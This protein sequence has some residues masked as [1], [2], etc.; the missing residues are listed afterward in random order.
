MPLSGFR[1][2]NERFVAEGLPPAPNPRNASPARCGRRIRA[3]PPNG[4]W[5]CGP[6]ASASAKGS[7]S[8]RVGR[9]CSGCA[10]AA[11]R[12]IRSRSA[13]SRSR[14]SRKRAAWELR[15][16]ELDYEIDGIVIKVDAYDQQA[17]LG[18]L[19]ERPRWAR[20]F[21][22]APITATTPAAQ[23]RDPRR[24]HRRVQPLAILEPVEVGGV[25]IFARDVAQRGGHQ[26]QGHPRGRRRDCPACRRRG[27]GMRRT[28]RQAPARHEAVRDAQRAGSTARLSLVKARGRGHA[29]PNRACPSRGLESLN[30][31]GDGRG[32]HRRRRRADG[33]PPVGSRTRAV[34]PPI[35]TGSRPSSCW[36]STASARSPRRTRS[37]RSPR[38]RRRFRSTSASSG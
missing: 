38:R 10:S 30:N 24:P 36:R 32:R 37:T 13:W 22:W 1:A 25:T 3:S 31:S 29:C 20:A 6:T 7:T 26:P 28:G 33:A 2:M 9:R 16:T 21:K 11:F 27:A 8:R 15:R 4:R 17:R 14:R 34:D 18:A 19:H 35:S 5:L 12:R 23:D